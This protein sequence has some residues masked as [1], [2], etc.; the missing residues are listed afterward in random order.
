MKRKGHLRFLEKKL[1]DVHGGK[2]CE[3][4]K[5]GPTLYPFACFKIF[6]LHII[7]VALLDL[8]PFFLHII[9]MG[10]FLA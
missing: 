4:A 5:F 6:N 3:P 1:V 2:K 10:I 8:P 9:Q 7:I